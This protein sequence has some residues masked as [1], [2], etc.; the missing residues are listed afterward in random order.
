MNGNSWEQETLSRL[1]YARQRGQQA[2]DEAA[3]WAEYTQILEKVLELDS[4]LSKHSATNSKAITNM[5]R[6]KSIKQCLILIAERNGGKL[7]TKKAVKE[8]MDA[9]IF[10][11]KDIARSNVFATLHL[12]KRSFKK[13]KAGI[14][15]LTEHGKK[16]LTKIIVG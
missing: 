8:L 4:K 12:S 15:K 1:A 11:D 16:L 7:I 9:G 13:Q 2:D 10:A 6:D 5:F 3:Y 14:Y